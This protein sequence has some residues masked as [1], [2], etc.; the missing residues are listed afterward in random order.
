[1]REGI[2]FPELFQNVDLIKGGGRPEYL[3]LTEE[4]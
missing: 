2:I 4:V 3:M 1:M